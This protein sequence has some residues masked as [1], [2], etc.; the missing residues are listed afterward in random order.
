MK[1]SAPE[2]EGCGCKI[3]LLELKEGKF[4]RDVPRSVTQGH[5]NSVCILS[6]MI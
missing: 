1:Q 5:T 2:M 3:Y 4:G 6:F